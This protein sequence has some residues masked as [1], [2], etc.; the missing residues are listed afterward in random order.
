MA[1]GFP[2]SIDNFTDPLSNSPLNSPSHSALHTDVN[3]AVEK[4]ET[5]MGLVYI[6]GNTF[7]ITNAAP[8]NLNNVFTA[9]YDNYLLTIQNT[10]NASGTSSVI[11]QWRVGGV[12]TTSGYFVAYAG[13]TSANATY[14]SANQGGAVGIDV[15]L[16]ET[17]AGS[18]SSAIQIMTPNTT[19]Q[20]AAYGQ[21]FSQGPGFYVTRQG[22]GALN[23]GTDFDGFTLRASTGTI[24]GSYRLY[25]YRK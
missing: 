7:S 10:T 5:Y 15:A 11:L 2:A 12:T 4:I 16:A 17:A 20:A 3:D 13:L 24:T 21:L 14:N 6:T 8:L 22:G 1:S 25:G 18:G 9:L 23:A 19:G